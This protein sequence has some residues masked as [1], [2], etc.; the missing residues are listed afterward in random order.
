MRTTLCVTY[1]ASLQVKTGKKHRQEPRT[2]LSRPRGPLVVEPPHGAFDRDLAPRDITHLLDLASHRGSFHHK[3][4]RIH[5]GRHPSRVLLQGGS[6]GYWDAGGFWYLHLPAAVK[7]VT[8]GGRGCGFAD[9]GGWLG[10]PQSD[11]P[12][13]LC[14][15]LLILLC[16]AFWSSLSRVS[17]CSLG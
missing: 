17:F 3:A 5:V 9:V 16:V 1:S 15:C 12:A 2:S 4:R 8:F 14:L 6:A 13:F 10:T 7:T 11:P